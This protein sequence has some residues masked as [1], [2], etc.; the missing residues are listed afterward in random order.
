ML[1][2]IAV[3]IVAGTAL[4]LSIASNALASLWLPLG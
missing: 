2:R 4:A 1:M 3:G